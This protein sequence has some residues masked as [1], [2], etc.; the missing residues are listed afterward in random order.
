MEKFL[1][2]PIE[3][4]QAILDAGFSCFGRMGYKKASVKDIA[5]DAG[6]SKS[7]IFHYFG[8][9][10]EMYLYLAEAAYKEVMDAFGEN[11]ELQ[12]KDFFRRIFAASKCKMKVIKKHPLLMTFL[13]GMYF[14]KDV[15]VYTEIQEFLKQGEFFRNKFTLSDIDNSKFKD[16]V[17]PELV[18]KL[19]VRYAEGYVS[20]VSLNTEADLEAL[21]EE[22]TECMHMLRVNFYKEE[23]RDE[24]N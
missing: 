2:L 9:K 20:S 5:V 8:S 17:K 11:F 23:Y 4:Q 13:S 19:L 10:K 18:L 24:C 22:F 15:E 3:K 6:I 16:T 14:E 12:T 1:A 7:M 21:M